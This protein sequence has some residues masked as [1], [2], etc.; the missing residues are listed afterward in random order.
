MFTHVPWRGVEKNPFDMR[1]KPFNMSADMEG[2][3]PADGPTV[4]ELV[5]R[6]SQP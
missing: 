2:S 6:L 5:E 3:T 1:T 4:V